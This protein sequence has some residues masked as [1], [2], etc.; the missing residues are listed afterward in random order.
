M[1]I[2]GGFI[3]MIAALHGAIAPAASGG[4][5][6]VLLQTIG[7]NLDTTNRGAITGWNTFTL[8]SFELL[9]S[10]GDPSGLT[11]SNNGSDSWTAENQGTQ[12][13]ADFPPEVLAYM[14][15]T[16]GSGSQTLLQITGATLGRSYELEFAVVQGYTDPGDSTNVTVN[17]V[18][19]QMG[20]PNVANQIYKK[21]F[22][23][24]GS[25]INIRFYPDPSIPAGYACMSGF[26]IKEY[27]N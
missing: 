23:A 8:T 14:V 12:I 4:G 27:S 26:R 11:L 7:V 9:N 6:P 22:T 18:T 16:D 21:T 2:N 19:Q 13:D 24:S 1:G 3:I 10:L 15:Y 5:E 17:G 20:G 25:T